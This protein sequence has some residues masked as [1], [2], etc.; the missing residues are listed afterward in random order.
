MLFFADDIALIAETQEDL[1]QLIK[2]MDEIF[3][4]DFRMKINVQ[5]TT[6]LI[7]GRENDTRI[8]IK[9]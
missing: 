5:K 6:V 2:T 8:Q 3:I 1:E 9:L 7:R 4:R